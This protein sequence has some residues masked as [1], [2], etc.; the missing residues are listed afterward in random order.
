MNELD[1]GGSSALASTTMNFSR[2]VRFTTPGSSA[3]FY[4][5][6]NSASLSHAYRIIGDPFSRVNHSYTITRELL[7]IDK[8]MCPLAPESI[9]T[10][11]CLGLNYEQHAREANAPI[12]KYPIIFYKPASAITGPYNPIHIPKLAAVHEELDYECELVI[13][14]GKKGRNISKENAF[15]Y[16]AGYSAGNDVS[17]RKWQLELGGGQWSTGKG[18]DSWGPIGPS[19]C[20]L[21]V[22]PNPNNLQIS[23]KVN[24]EQRQSSNTKDMIFNVPEIIAFV[25]TGCT[26]LP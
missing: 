3:C 12:P 13:V 4:G 2:L 16:V 7:K 8:L 6:A 10:V 15:D 23:T 18:F 19:I 5:D 1:Y 17:H 21:S 20:S 25:S 22:I 14:I 11:R 9:G 24:G 26:L